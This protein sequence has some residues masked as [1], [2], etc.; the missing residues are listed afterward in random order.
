MQPVALYHDDEWGVPQHD[1]HMLWEMLVLEGF[2]AGLS[3]RTVL[4]KREAFR[5][6][7]AGFAPEKVTHF[8]ERQ[9]SRLSGRGSPTVRPISQ[10]RR[11]DDDERESAWATRAD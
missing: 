10:C 1:A 8:G 2:Q 5:K 4:H 3:W 6:A 7:F 9:I 11:F